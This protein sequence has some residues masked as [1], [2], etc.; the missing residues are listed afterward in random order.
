MRYHQHR[1]AVLVSVLLV[2]GLCGFAGAAR[3]QN[4]PEEIE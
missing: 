3:A 2:V 1:G 4:P